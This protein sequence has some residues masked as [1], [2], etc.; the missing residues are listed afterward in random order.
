MVFIFQNLILRWLILR[1]RKKISKPISWTNCSTSI[2][3]PLYRYLIGIRISG[4]LVGY[5]QMTIN[6]SIFANEIQ[7]LCSNSSSECIISKTLCP[8]LKIPY[9]SKLIVETVTELGGPQLNDNNS[10]EFFQRSSKFVSKFKG[11]MST[12]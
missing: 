6:L 11:G 12:F 5:I 3:T 4:N 10:L 8:L 7:N 9:H 1:H 2:F